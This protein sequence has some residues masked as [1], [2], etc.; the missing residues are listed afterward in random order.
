MILVITTRYD[1]SHDREELAL[2]KCIGNPEEVAHELAP[3][4]EE[5]RAKRR[6]QGSEGERVMRFSGTV[7]DCG[8]NIHTGA[9]RTKMRDQSGHP[10]ASLS[11]KENG[12]GVEEKNEDFIWDVD[13]EGHWDHSVRD[14]KEP[15]GYV[16]V[17]FRDG[18]SGSLN[19]GLGMISTG[20]PLSD[21]Q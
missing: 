10:E 7:S 14:I 17:E 6:V 19:R 8:L 9:V 16:G 20:Q 5:P 15:A 13:L 11:R 21:H 12:N 3:Q 1:K 2:E 4:E 18:T